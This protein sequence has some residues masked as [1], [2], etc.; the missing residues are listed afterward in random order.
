[1]KENN[2]VVHGHLQFSPWG[3]LLSE[4]ANEISV[5][6]CHY[7]LNKHNNETARD[8]WE[9]GR[10]EDRSVCPLCSGLHVQYN[11]SD[12]KFRRRKTKVIFKL[13]LSSD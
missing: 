12:N 5:V 10:D 9:E 4:I 13:I 7:F 3:F 8:K 6:F 2:Q 11:G 1:M